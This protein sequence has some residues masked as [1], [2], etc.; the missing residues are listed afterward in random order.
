MK[1]LRDLKDSKL[2]ILQAR[3][4]EEALLWTEIEAGFEADNL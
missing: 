4:N 1:D 2:Q 3:R